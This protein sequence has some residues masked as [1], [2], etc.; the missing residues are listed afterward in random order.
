MYGHTLL[1]PI[2]DLGP[3]V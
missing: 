2:N 3:T 1:L